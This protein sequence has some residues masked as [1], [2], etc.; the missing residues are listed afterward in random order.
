VTT[1][2]NRARDRVP[3]RQRGPVGDT[4]FVGCEETADSRADAEERE[5]VRGHN[6]AVD[7][8]RVVAGGHEE[9]R[10]RIVSREAL[11]C[12]ALL[13]EMHVVRIRHGPQDAPVP[14][15]R[16]NRHNSFW[17]INRQL[18]E[19]ICVHECQDG[20]RG[21]NGEGEGEEGGQ[22][23]D[24]V[25]C[26]TAEAVPKVQSRLLQTRPASDLAHLL[27]VALHPAEFEPRMASRLGGRQTAPL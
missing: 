8:L 12:M 3:G 23:K 2:T 21:T 4:I 19:E 24:R 5:E 20:R 9:R 22:G 27:F 13:A 6:G 1:Q 11:Q 26:E 7:L 14:S 18:L 10:R 15:C 25:A 16:G 17:M